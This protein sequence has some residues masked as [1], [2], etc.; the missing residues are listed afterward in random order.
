[1]NHLDPWLEG[2]M[3][4]GRGGGCVKGHLKLFLDLYRSATGQKGKWAYAIGGKTIEKI[5]GYGKIVLWATG[6]KGK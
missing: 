2:G 3:P 6:Q 4:R 5:N 1:M